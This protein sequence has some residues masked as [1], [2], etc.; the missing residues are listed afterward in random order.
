MSCLA[1][2]A[3]STAAYALVAAAIKWRLDHLVAPTPKKDSHAQEPT[4]GH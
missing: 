2:V 4:R 1:L 3:C